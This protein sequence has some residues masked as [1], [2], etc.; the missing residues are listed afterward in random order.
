[1]VEHPKLLVIGLDAGDKD[2]ILSWA[3]SGDL[4]T[5][6]RLLEV[7]AW[8][9]A[10]GLVGMHAA[11]E[12]HSLFTAVTPARHGRH[13]GRQ[14]RVGTYEMYRF[15][16]T[17]LKREAFWNELGRAQRRVAVIDVP[18]VRLSEKLNGIHVLDW[19]THAADTGFSTW[20]PQ[21]AGQLQ[22]QFGLDPVSLCDDKQMH[23]AED[24][25]AFR[26]ALVARVGTK[27]AASQHLLR[28]EPWDLFMTVFG[29]AHCI[30]HQCWHLHDPRHPSHNS[31]IA[32]AIGDPLRSVYRALDDGI[33]QLLAAVGPETRILFFSSHGMGP[34]YTGAHLLSEILMRLGHQPLPQEPRWPWRAVRWGWRQLPLRLRRRLVPLQK[35]GVDLVWPAL[36]GRSRC[37]DVPNGEV[38]GGIRV[39]LVG[40]E[41]QGKITP[42]VEYDTFCDALTRDLCALVNADTGQPAVRRVLRTV[43]L[44][45]GPYLGDLPDLL[46]EW[47]ND[48]ALSVVHSPKTGTI[49]REMPTHRTGHHTAQGL[50]IAAGP[51]IRPQRIGDAVSVID[52]APTIAALLDVTLPDVDGHPVPVCIPGL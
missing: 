1:M 7:G 23:T 27:V 3:A 50:F 12:W 46:V 15:R 11:A 2:L 44:Y 45:P 6:R 52:I 42:G 43:D 5:F 14:I 8:A 39:N 4:P 38:Y 24:F 25:A 34:N 31:S 41:P 26:D 19:M 28:Q 21:L 49:R 30:G 13:G 22:K 51:G 37:F 40:R 47:A 20:P 35:A 9:P 36:D 32:K 48:A 17:D 10:A 29:E 18:Y 16:P 33:A